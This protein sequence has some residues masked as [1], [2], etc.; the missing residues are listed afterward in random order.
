MTFN[1]TLLSMC[2]VTALTACG[3]SNKDQNEAVNQ[4]TDDIPVVTVPVET[5]VSGK[6]IK[7]VLANAKLTIYKYV[8]GEA[9]K[10]TS[11]EL[12]EENLT[13]DANG[14]Y[15]FTLLNINNA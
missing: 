1:K 11:E 10:L 3:S 15:T 14:N 13:T 8:N 6:A 9:V 4:D 7:G 12:K 5:A 2:V